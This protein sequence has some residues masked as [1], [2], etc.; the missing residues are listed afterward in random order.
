MQAIQRISQ[1]LSLHS[2]RDSPK[3]CLADCFLDL[4]RTS[5]FIFAFLLRGFN[6]KQ[7]F[8]GVA[9]CKLLVASLQRIKSDQSLLLLDEGREPSLALDRL[10]AFVQSRTIK[11][12]FV[13]HVQPEEYDSGENDEDVHVGVVNLTLRHQV[14]RRGRYEER[15][16]DLSELRERVGQRPAVVGDQGSPCMFLL[17]FLAPAHAEVDF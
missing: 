7:K 17:S 6:R 1:H 11:F 2:S 9:D 14:V 16:A 10:F 15:L 12:V 13:P 3:C 4:S 8:R 5:V